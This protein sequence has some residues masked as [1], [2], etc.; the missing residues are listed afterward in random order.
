MAASLEKITIPICKD[1]NTP[2][3]PDNKNEDEDTKGIA[4]DHAKDAKELRKKNQ[5]EEIEQKRSR[6]RFFGERIR[7]WVRAIFIAFTAICA[8]A[9]PFVYL[10]HLLAPT[11]WRWL[12]INEVQTI[13]D[14]SASIITGVAVSIGI[15]LLL[16]DKKDTSAK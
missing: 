16:G 9:I 4:T 1:D 6:M 13:K 14:L 7:F 8:I 11:N 15:T 2:L 10:W 12:D 5:E 3:I